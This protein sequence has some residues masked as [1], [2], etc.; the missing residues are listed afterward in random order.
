VITGSISSVLLVDYARLYHQR[1]H[2]DIVSLI[3]RAMTRSAVLLVPLMILL[4]IVAPSLMEVLF[5]KSYRDAALFFRIYLLLLPMRTLTFGALLQSAGRSRLILV[6]S[7]LDLAANAAL[8]WYL[9]GALG[10]AGAALANILATYLVFVPV[11]LWAL[12]A[13]LQTTTRR[14]L[15]WN[16]LARILGAALL[17]GVP[18]FALHYWLP[19]PVLFKLATASVVFTGVGALM[20][21]RLGLIL[22]EELR[23]LARLAFRP[24]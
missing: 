4:L 19:V 3:H 16:S 14:L 1:N 17:A 12:K 13:T 5:G 24:R 7:I 2:A 22:P 8:G 11:S 6:Q 15:P 9:T 21:I 18:A 20:L 10:P 23:S